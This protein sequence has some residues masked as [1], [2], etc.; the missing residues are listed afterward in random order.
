MAFQRDKF[1]DF[2]RVLEDIQHADDPEMG[3]VAEN[4]VLEERLTDRREDSYAE[5]ALSPEAVDTWQ[6]THEEYIFDRIAPAR[7]TPETFTDLNRINML[8]ELD[9]AQFLVRLENIDALK[10]LAK[11]EDDTARLIETFQAFL[12]NRNSNAAHIIEDFFDKC[13]RIK[14]ELDEPDELSIAADPTPS[15]NGES[16]GEIEIG[17]SNLYRLVSHWA[18][19]EVKREYRQQSAAAVE[20]V[21]TEDPNNIAALLEKGFLLLDQDPADVGGF[22]AAQLRRSPHVLGLRIGELRA[23][24]ETDETVEPERWGYLIDEFS[25]RKTVIQ[26]ENAR[27]ELRHANGTTLEVLEALRRQI[28]TELAELPPPLQKN[29]EWVRTTVQKRL[30][31]GIHL[32]NALTDE[33]VPRVQENYKKHDLALQGIIEQCVAASS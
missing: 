2:R 8:P 31:D 1:D 4:F 10:K 25:N 22:F 17:L 24:V 23:R 29:E 12:A 18:D 33:A 21:L 20:K 15:A 16:T 13:K 3:L 14:G 30:F 9:G 27:Q 28:H 11:T 5:Y 7:G 19:R 26:L 6:D 32:D